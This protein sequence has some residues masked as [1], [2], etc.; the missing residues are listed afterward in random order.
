MKVVP[1]SQARETSSFTNIHQGAVEAYID[2]IDH[3][4]EAT[5]RQKDNDRAAKALLCQLAYE[6]ANKDCRTIIR[7]LRATTRDISEFV[8]ACQD[9]STQQHQASLLA[10][11]ITGDPRSYNYGKPSHV[12]KDV[13][14][15]GKGEKVMTSFPL[16]IVC[17]VA[18]ADIGQRNA[19]LI[20]TKTANLFRETSKGAPAPAPPTLIGAFRTAITIRE[21]REMHSFRPS[22]SHPWKPRAR[23]SNHK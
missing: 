12:S 2:F 10:A 21:C 7:P 3:L 4:L 17:T 5:E 15:D 1:D 18:R 9:V 16:R 20:L 8:K 13:H 14:P 23:L 6:N 11:T 22:S 19:T